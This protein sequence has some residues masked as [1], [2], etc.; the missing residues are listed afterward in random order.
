MALLSGPY[1]LEKYPLISNID[2]SSITL[3]IS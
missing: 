1:Q 2:L 3:C